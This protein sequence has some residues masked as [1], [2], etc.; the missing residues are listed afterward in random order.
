[1]CIDLRVRYSFSE[2]R[3]WS[4]NPEVLSGIIPTVEK[5]WHSHDVI[6]H[7]W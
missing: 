7:V 3:T 5:P 1:M 2:N 4:T 6:Y